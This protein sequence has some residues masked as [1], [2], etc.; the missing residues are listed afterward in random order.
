[1]GTL[2]SGVVPQP[3]RLAKQRK[4]SSALL[5]E[6]YLLAM[7]A[8]MIAEHRRQ[9]SSAAGST[10]VVSVTNLI[11]LRSGRSCTMERKDRSFQ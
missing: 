9:V 1:M 8:A 5:D 2:L 4:S 11:N 10:G 7:N 3:R 6:R